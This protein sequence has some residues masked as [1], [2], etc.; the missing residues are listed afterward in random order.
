MHVHC[1]YVFNYYKFCVLGYWNLVFIRFIV[2]NV[3]V[4]KLL[5]KS[6]HVLVSHIKRL[7]IT[8]LLGNIGNIYLQYVKI[9]NSIHERRVFRLTLQ[10]N[11]AHKHRIKI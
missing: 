2:V 9:I 11:N 10:C 6:R 5:N 7:K 4:S 3:V 8:S 1:F